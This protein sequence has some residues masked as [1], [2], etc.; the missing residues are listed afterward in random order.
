MKWFSPALIA[1]FMLIV[2]SVCTA[3]YVAD[4]RPIG[5]SK[6]SKVF[7]YEEFFVEPENGNAFSNIFFIDTEKNAPL[8]G[9]PIKGAAG[10][11]DDY[12][13]A[14]SEAAA[15]ASR[16]IKKYNLEADPGHLVAFAPVTEVS[17]ALDSLRYYAFPTLPSVGD[18]YT[19]ILEKVTLP[20]PDTCQDPEG[21]GFRLTLAEIH[22]EPA[23]LKVYEDT[24]VAKE[25]N[26]PT[27]YRLGGIVTSSFH[28]TLQV[29]LV[30]VISRGFDGDNAHWLAVPFKV[31]A[32]P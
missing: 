2:P 12:K 27:A 13:G 17:A 6:D 9:S 25:R 14:R 8:A 29:A 5:F 28:Q 21:T 20:V 11:I 22:G 24:V 3:G 32:I 31:P 18:S 30:Q 1:I 23:R 19:L 26:C 16:L 7:A 10:D 15:K 4:I